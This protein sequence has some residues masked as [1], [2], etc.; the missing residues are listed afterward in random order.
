MTTVSTLEGKLIAAVQG[1]DKLWAFKS[2]LEIPLE[3]VTGVRS[4][5]D[6]RVG[7]S[8]HAEPTSR[9]FIQ[10]FAILWR[11]WLH[12]QENFGL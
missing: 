8:A 5:A 6:E 2:R 3:H 7:V 4:A 9:A 12:T 11:N 1:W 10:L